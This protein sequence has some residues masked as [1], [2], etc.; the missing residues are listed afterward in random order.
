MLFEV[1]AQFAGAGVVSELDD[2]RG[3]SAGRGEVRPGG[4]IVWVVVV[5]VGR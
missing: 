2:A 5:G 3:A 1:D 4:A